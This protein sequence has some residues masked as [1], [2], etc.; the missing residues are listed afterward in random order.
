MCKSGV[1]SSAENYRPVPLTSVAVKIVECFVHR[2]VIKPSQQSQ[3]A[4][5]VIISM[6][7]ISPVN[8]SLSYM[9]MY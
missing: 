1:R 9:Y 3:F 6:V 4:S 8:V 5:N 2:H 7:F